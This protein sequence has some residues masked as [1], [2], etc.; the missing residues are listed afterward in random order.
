MG[1]A[2]VMEV[3]RRQL[4][5]ETLAAG[6]GVASADVAAAQA[7]A[8]ADPSGGGGG[9]SWRRASQL[10]AVLLLS[11]AAIHWTLGERVLSAIKHLARID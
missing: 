9:G 11:S 10:Q 7:A 4:T 1:G 6:E 5:E 8:E 3:A 2:V